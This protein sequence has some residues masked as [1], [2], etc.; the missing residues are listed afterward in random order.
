L[1]P[2]GPSASDRPGAV[3]R[4]PAVSRGKA[5]SEQRGLIL[6]T[7]DG[8]FSNRLTHPRYEVPKTYVVQVA[9]KP[10]PETLEKICRGVHLSEGLARRKGR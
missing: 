10:E 5:R 8:E 4:R 7:N 6:V 2:C 1:G 9:G 3:P